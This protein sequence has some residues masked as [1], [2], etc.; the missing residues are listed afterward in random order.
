MTINIEASFVM[1]LQYYLL[2]HSQVVGL[3]NLF[4]NVKVSKAGIFPV[5]N[6]RK[7]HGP[8]GDTHT[9]PLSGSLGILMP[10]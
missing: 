7:E 3:H 9:R 5:E 4:Q 8:C 10:R 6:S 1:K 2:P